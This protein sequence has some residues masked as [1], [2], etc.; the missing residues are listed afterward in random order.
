VDVARQRFAGAVEV[1]VADNVSTDEHGDWH[2]FRLMFYD[3]PL[4]YI[5]GRNM[6][7]FLDRYWYGPNR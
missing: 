7:G 3:G 6:R 4:F 2:Y 1:I 5:G